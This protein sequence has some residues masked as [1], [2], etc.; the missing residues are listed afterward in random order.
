MSKLK[1][2]L[3]TVACIIAV[4]A[5]VAG[6]VI[7]HGRKADYN[8]EAKS[9]IAMGTVVTVKIYNDIQTNLIPNVNSVIDSLENT[10]SWR[11]EASPVAA[12]N[13]TGRCENPMVAEIINSCRKISDS[14]DGSFDLTVGK[15]S[16]LW[17]FGGDN[18]RLPDESEIKNAL[19]FV[20]Y[21]KLETTGSE[22]FCADGQQSDL[23]AIGKGLACDVVR[24][25][26]EASE[27][28]GAVVSVGGSICAFG[29]RNKAGDKWRIAIKHP[30]KENE[31]IGVVCLNEGFVSTSGDYEKYF[32]LD[33]VRY[34][35][36]L[37]A[38]TGYP[39][40]SNLKSVTVVC[41]SGMLSDALSTACFILGKEKSEELLKEYNASAV[42]VD[43]EG[44]ITVSGDIEFEEYGY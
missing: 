23:G 24:E 38:K 32:E 7:H 15:V 10:I 43:S 13:K 8:V 37:D 18:E 3:I 36:I 16:T 14:T 2:A 39:A 40:K 35:H 22:A 34:H 26:L 21:K 33:G 9:S 6:A 41:N 28:K 5:V 12:L 25:Y 44:K 27:V 31:F 4:T 11:K 19:R 20:D 17:D 42:F 1:K 30:E 29:S